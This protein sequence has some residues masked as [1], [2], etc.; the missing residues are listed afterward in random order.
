VREGWGVND[1]TEAT[2]GAEA[3]DL[4]E[5]GKYDLVVTDYTMP[6]LDGRGVIEYIRHRS[7]NRFVPVLVVT[8]ETD[9]AKLAAVRQLG[10][11]AIFDKRFSPEA[12]RAVLD[13]LR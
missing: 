5:G 9:P 10:V 7:A 4:L 13:G 3:V 8:S 11:S 1:V 2:N 6:F 12:A